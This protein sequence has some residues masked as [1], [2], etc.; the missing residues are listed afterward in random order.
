MP[1]IER[2]FMKAAKE[3]GVDLA[4]YGLSSN[5]KELTRVTKQVSDK[6]EAAFKTFRRLFKDLSEAPEML[7]LG[8]LIQYLG[9]NRYEVEIEALK[10]IVNE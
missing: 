2:F 6:N 1:A 5:I 10:K 4:L 9:E 8:N 7:R 3:I